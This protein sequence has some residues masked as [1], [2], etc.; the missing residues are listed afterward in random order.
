MKV[1][2]ILLGSGLSAGA[3]VTDMAANLLLAY[4][5]G[6][7][8]WVILLGFGNEKALPYYL[9]SRI[10][11]VCGSI[12]WHRVA[13]IESTLD[14]LNEWWLA[15]TDYTRHWLPTGVSWSP[16][17]IDITNNYFQMGVVAGL[18]LMTL[19]S[20]MLAK[21]FSFVGRRI[22]K[23][24]DFPRSWGLFSERLLPYFLSVLRCA[25]QDRT[26]ISHSCSFISLL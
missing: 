26:L 8:S 24:P 15:K 9:L 3:R 2:F 22:R 7:R 18:L 4:R 20:A 21:R 6:L 13:L 19:V 10:N 11:I 5:H 14:H 17:H 12:D 1:V 25:F 23:T 16:D